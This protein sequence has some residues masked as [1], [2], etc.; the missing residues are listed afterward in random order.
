M[1]LQG[2]RLP[3]PVLD[4]LAVGRGGP[5]AIGS[6][7]TAQHSKNL[8]LVRALVTLLHRTDHPDRAVVEAAYRTLGRLPADHRRAA[9]SHPPVAA[10][11]FGT[12][13]LLRRGEPAATYPGLLAAV[14]VAAAVRAG[15]D[16]DLDVP[17]DVATPGRLDLPGLGTVVV[18]AHAS[19][20]RVRS[21]DGRA[22]VWCARER[23]EIGPGRPAPDAR[24][25]PTPQLRVAHDGLSLTLLLDIPTWRHVPRT[26]ETGSHQV[27]GEVGDPRRWRHRLDGAWRL[28]T[29][30]HRPVAEELSAALGVLVPLTEPPAGIRSGTFHHGFGSVAMSIPPDDRLAAVTLAHEIQHLK[31]AALTDLF[32]LVGPGPEELFYAPWRPDP[33]PLDGLLHGAYAHLGVARFWRRERRRE[34]DP[35]ARHHA[36]VEFGRW[37]RAAG[38]TVRVL[39]AQP[40]LTP[41]GR[42]V[43]RG[44]AGVLQRWRAEPVPPEAAAEAD[45][46]L[47]A[48]RSRWE[49]ARAGAR[50]G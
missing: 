43:V 21:A 13:S 27:S 12:A 33:R 1:T 10:W 3:R 9:V 31:L 4:E 36:E 19:R 8:L 40:R 7:R 29:R 6:L 44:M 15:V 50:P 32:A 48:H 38:D 47:G 39:A 23:V 22:E 24:W 42:H 14:A 41:V 11:A 5:D 2:H 35:A 46:L 25:R 45:R 37:V 17:L 49:R 34:R 20:A 30:G 18:P 16:A 28:L 26:V